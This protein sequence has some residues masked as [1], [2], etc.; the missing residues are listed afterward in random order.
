MSKVQS[1]K[2]PRNKTQR[3]YR[4]D[5]YTINDSIGYLVSRLS[6]TLGREID[7]RMVELGLTDA[8]WK[9]LLLLQQGACTTAADISRMV[10]LDTGAVTRLL[11]RVEG[12]GLIRRVRSAADRR[13]INLELTDE[14]RRVANEVPAIITGLANHFLEGFAVEE[15]EQF[16]DYLNRALENLE[17]LA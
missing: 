5:S 12:K 3:F 4:A 16:K 7:R 17:H 1:N 10:G 15:Y 11:D 8:Q 9:P 14:G 13:V 6:Q 2:T